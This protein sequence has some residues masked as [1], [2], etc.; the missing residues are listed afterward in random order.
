MNSPEMMINLDDILSEKLMP[1]SLLY[2]EGPK[3]NDILSSG[4][5]KL[6]SFNNITNAMMRA[7]P[8]DG[9]VNSAFKFMKFHR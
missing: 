1:M 2:I 4:N 5:V 9:D 3:G 7:N 6:E 8:M